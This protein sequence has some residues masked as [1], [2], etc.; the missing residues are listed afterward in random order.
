M[1]IASVTLAHPLSCGVIVDA[2]KSASW[3]DWHVV[4]ATGAGTENDA[5]QTVVNAAIAEGRW[6]EVPWRD[7]FSSMRNQALGLAAQSILLGVER[8]AGHLTRPDWLLILDTDERIIC[9]DPGMLRQALQQLGGQAQ[10]ASAWYVNGEYCKPRLIKVPLEGEFI[11]R[12]H[13]EWVPKNGVGATLPIE[14]ISFDELTKS[15]DDLVEKAAR[16]LR[17][18]T[19]DTA[20]RPEEW[21]P[22]HY[23]GVT[24]ERMG[25]LPSALAAFEVAASKDSR[26]MREWGNRGWSYF[27]A[28]QVAL[29]L[30]EPDRARE[31]AARGVSI[32][33]VP[34]LLL[35]LG[36]AHY[37]LKRPDTAL[38]FAML[39]ADA[40]MAEGWGQRVRRVGSTYPPAL[41][42]LPYE[43]MSLSFAAMGQ[44][45]LAQQ[46]TAKMEEARAMR[47]ARE[48]VVRDGASADD[49]ASAG[50]GV[51]AKPNGA[52]HGSL[53]VPQ[54]EPRLL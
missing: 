40:G 42:E 43:L 44:P 48:E 11:W 54:R 22:W 1:K 18:L 21:R 34:E 13:E 38:Q 7:S 37:S 9:H 5:L 32:Y 33:P 53:F 25:D 36:H 8:G 24:Y 23:L 3:C 52:D 35:T 28:A 19:L 15:P 31:L 27:R 29:A 10:V 20:E 51:A 39:A 2:L 47:L 12:T 45:D 4:V 16:D 14:L 6:Y 50:S 41:Y 49:E 17:L 46:A 26:G 30:E